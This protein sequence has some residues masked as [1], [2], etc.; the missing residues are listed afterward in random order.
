M[1]LNEPDNDLKKTNAITWQLNV[2]GVQ[3]LLYDFTSQMQEYEALIKR[4]ESEPIVFEIDS[5]SQLPR[6][7]IQARI[8]TKISQKKLADQL[9]IEEGLLQRYEDREYESATLTQLLEV[10]QLLGISIQQKTTFKVAAP[11]KTA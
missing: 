2:D 11:L 5:L 9:G 10:S 6:V 7:L 8:A 3:S 1:V 4:E